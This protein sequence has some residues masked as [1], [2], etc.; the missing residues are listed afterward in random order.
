MSVFVVSGEPGCKLVVEKNAIAVV[1]D[2]LRASATINVLFHLGAKEILVVSEVK[3]AFELKNKYP[4][5]ILV[6]ER[7]NIKIPGFDF[8][9]SPVEILKLG[10][11]FFKNKKI[12]FTSTTGAKRIIACKGAEEVFVGS[13]VNAQAVA[14]IAFELA[15]RKNKDIIIIPAGVYGK[16]DWSTEDLFASLFIAEKIPLPLE[17]VYPDIKEPGDL[18]NA[19]F[20]SCHGK[21]LIK[22]GFKHDVEF[23]SDTDL[24][25]TVAKVVKFEGN[26]AILKSYVII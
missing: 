5:A 22:A 16:K 9:N 4:D 20:N 7:K 21:E 6:G 24:M 3:Q 19:F 12:I 14:K 17:K 18:K 23:C 26:T 10:E 11:N 2:A 15:K 25:D 1:V 8:G 13:C